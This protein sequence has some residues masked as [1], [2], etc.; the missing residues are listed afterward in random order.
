MNIKKWSSIE[1][2]IA[3]FCLLFV[4]ALIYVVALDL[5][6][7]RDYLLTRTLPYD[8][9]VWDVKGTKVTLLV[10][11]HELTSIEQINLNSHDVSLLNVKGKLIPERSDKFEIKLSSENKLSMCSRRLD[12]TCFDL[13]AS[14]P[15]FDIVSKHSTEGE[16]QNF[17]KSEAKS[18]NIF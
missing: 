4:C 12:S 18:N 8:A 1:K 5:R 16:I 17:F 11:P 14:K 7:K 13:A 9:M 15:L 2:C 6:F 10:M 3:L